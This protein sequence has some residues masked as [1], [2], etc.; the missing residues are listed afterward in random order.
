MTDYGEIS[1]SRAFMPVGDRFRRYKVLIDGSK[2]GTVGNGE[3]VTFTT[4][5]G[6]HRVRLKVDWLGSP[7]VLVVVQAGETTILAA[8]A[9]PIPNSPMAFLFSLFNPGKYIWL[10]RHAR[11]D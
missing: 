5:V 10:E 6:A 8:S 4:E 9:K 7:E 1:I 11:A 2:V 3:T